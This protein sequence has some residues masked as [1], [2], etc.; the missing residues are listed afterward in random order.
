MHNTNLSFQNEFGHGNIPNQGRDVQRIRTRGTANWAALHSRC[1]D[2][3][4]QSRP[5]PQQRFHCVKGHR[6]S[7]Q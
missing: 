7:Q 6:D 3:C 1:Y 2:Y 5:V 4:A